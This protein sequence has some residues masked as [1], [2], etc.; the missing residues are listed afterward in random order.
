MENNLNIAKKN[1]TELLQ[2]DS[3]K[4]NLQIGVDFTLLSKS[5][6]A[7]YKK[8]KDFY[9]IALAPC[10]VSS[11]KA[12][13]KISIYDMIKEINILIESIT[14][15]NEL[16]SEELFTN[17]LS[18]FYDESLDEIYIDLKQAYLYIKKN[19]DS[20]NI[21]DSIEYVSDVDISNDIK[22][23]ENPLINFN[24]LSLVVWSG[25]TKHILQQMNILDLEDI[26][27][28]YME[29]NTNITIYENNTLQYK[30]DEES[31]DIKDSSIDIIEQMLILPD[32]LNYDKDEVE[33]MKSRLAK[34]NIKYLQTLKE[35]DIKIK[36]INSNLTDEPEFS[37]LKY[38][39]PPCWVR[40]GKTW[41]D[42]PGIYRN[43]SIVAKIGYSN[44]SYANVHSSKNLELHETAHAI[45][46][47]VLNK[48]SNSEEFMEVFAQE[49]YKLYDPKQVAHAYISK[50]IEEFF[51]ESFV[52]YYL[53]EDSKNTLKENCPLTYD[54][55][56]KLELNY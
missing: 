25:E 45:D 46:K 38:Q 54:F 44:P 36:L 5:L 22:A 2:N 42:V 13:R 16:L 56:E 49:R 24:S 29:N 23:K 35:K 39:L 10:N 15:K 19:T 6:K 33:N 28:Y 41:K 48:K 50:F 34:I 52:H 31:E 20:L 37:D 51:A 12:N 55:L 7:F 4:V 3:L 14:D 18:E 47:N 9:C 1:N 11:E 8:E 43:N 17:N 32:D 26:H 21:E 30:F 40:S 27:S 53:D